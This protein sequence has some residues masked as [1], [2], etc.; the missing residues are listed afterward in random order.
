MQVPIIT[1]SSTSR[2]FLS[3]LNN[4]DL[5]LL[6]LWGRT[7]TTVVDDSMASFLAEALAS[8]KFSVDSGFDVDERERKWDTFSVIFQVIAAVSHVSKR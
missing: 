8:M 4:K 7:R 1:S 6:L 3:S 5:D 2:F